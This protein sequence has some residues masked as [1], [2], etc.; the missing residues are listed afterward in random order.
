MA[1]IGMHHL[2]TKR[3]DGVYYVEVAIRSALYMYELRSE[4][5]YRLFT[6]MVNRN[7]G[8]AINVLREWAINKGHERIKQ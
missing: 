8:Y 1:D 3:Q 7:Q 4:W 5:A 6:K 2:S